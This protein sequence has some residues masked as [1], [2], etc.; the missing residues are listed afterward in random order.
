MTYTTRE[1][2][3]KAADNELIDGMAVGVLLVR[4]CQSR[5]QTFHFPL[6][7]SVCGAVYCSSRSCV[8]LPRQMEDTS[9]LH[10]QCLTKGL[11]LEYICSAQ[12]GNL[13]NLEIA[14]R[15]LGIP[16]LR[17]TFAQS[18]DCVNHVC[19]IL[20]SH[21]PVAVQMYAQQRVIYSVA[22]RM[23]DILD[24]PSLKLSANYCCVFLV[25]FWYSAGTRVTSIVAYSDFTSKYPDYVLSKV[26]LVSTKLSLPELGYFARQ[27]QSRHFFVASLVTMRW[28]L[29]MRV[30]VKDCTLQV[31]NLEITR[32]QCAISGF[33]ECATQSRDCANSQI[34]RNIS[35]SGSS[36]D[37]VEEC[38]YAFTQ[39]RISSSIKFIYVW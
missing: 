33:Q 29:H 23:E 8:S 27:T 11:G 36:I 4:N 16:R 38:D 10:L 6:F 31:R 3:E 17:N 25:I 35:T 26:G 24:E 22:R 20:R 9:N 7:N 32:L 34:A 30:G 37:Q 5:S 2:A 28:F 19:A 39:V 13:R 21:A 14:L 15:I 1:G 18:R 12:S